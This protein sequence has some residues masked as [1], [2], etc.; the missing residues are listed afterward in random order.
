MTDTKSH[1]SLTDAEI[2]GIALKYFARCY[3]E[4]TPS[5]FIDMAR[6]AISL[7]RTA[8]PALG[9]VL[10]DEQIMEIVR[11]S[12]AG[13]KAMPDVEWVA[14]ARALLAASTAQA[15]EVTKPG[16]PFAA[17]DSHVR[18]RGHNLTDG[19]AKTATG[20]GEANSVSQVGAQA[21][22]GPSRFKS[23]ADLLDAPSLHTQVYVAATMLHGWPHDVAWEVAKSAEKTYGE[24]ACRDVDGLN[25]VLVEALRADGECA[26]LRSQPA[27]DGGEK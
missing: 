25:A 16:E 13:S 8:A 6:E 4:A 3:V 18:G 10:T 15:T 24:E 12:T 2:R 7:A 20:D 27:T 1:A 9:Q 21:E 19:S 14:F 22:R 5:A 23:T 17:A 26:A 11:Y